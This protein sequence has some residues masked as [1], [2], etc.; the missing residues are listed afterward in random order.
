MAQTEGRQRF[1]A[2]AV[3]IIILILV[4][5]TL[6]GVAVDRAILRFGSTIWFALL[7]GIVGLALGLA[8]A[9]VTVADLLNWRAL[10]SSRIDPG[11]P[12]PHGGTVAI[13]GRIAC[14]QSPLT[15]P[16]LERP[17]AAFML[18]I[19][20]Q[21]R[22]L[23]DS[24][25]S[26]RSQL[27]GLEF[28]LSEAILDTGSQKLR[29]LAL[30]HVDPSFR[31][32]AQG[33]ETGKRALDYLESLREA[34]RNLDQADAE[35]CLIS[36]RSRLPPPAHQRLFIT[37]TQAS[38]NQMSVTEDIVPVDEPVTVLAH[39]RAARDELSGDRRCGMKIFKGSIDE[40]LKQLR[41]EYFGYARVAIPS[42]VVGAA[43]LTCGYWWPG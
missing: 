33:G 3:L 39:F 14:P 16:I 32:I 20:G 10:R 13:S 28:A 12:L 27:C 31:T 23:S 22:N 26:Y 7:P 6:L 19:T 38:S 9:W 18:R 21:R 30:P 5:L 42:I 25:G 43:L 29:L 1:I 2:R 34:G 41:K 40:C 35:G 17:C 8:C 15:S 37:E 24:G 4:V 36:A 11:Q